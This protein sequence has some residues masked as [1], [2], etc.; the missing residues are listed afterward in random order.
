MKI[1]GLFGFSTSL[2]TDVKVVNEAVFSSTNG[3][4]KWKFMGITLFDR[5]YNES[6]GKVEFLDKE[7]A[8]TTAIGFSKKKKDEMNIVWRRRAT[9]IQTYLQ[10]KGRVLIPSLIG[11]SQTTV[12]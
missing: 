2:N 7:S 3:Y 12:Q 11:M 6:I 4:K 1:K 8:A 5:D 9:V 10:Q